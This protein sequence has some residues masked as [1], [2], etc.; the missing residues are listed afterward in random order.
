MLGCIVNRFLAA[1]PSDVCERQGGEFT[2][3]VPSAG[4]SAGQN[5]RNQAMNSIFGQ[6]PRIGVR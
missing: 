3:Y 5:P 1:R 6:R 2:R 4:G